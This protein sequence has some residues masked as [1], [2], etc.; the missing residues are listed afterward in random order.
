MIS[1]PKIRSKGNSK[2]SNCISK[3][4]HQ[5]V[6]N[7]GH[8]N[9][10]SNSSFRKNTTRAQTAHNW[11]TT[12]FVQDFFQCSCICLAS[13]LVW[14]ADIFWRPQFPFLLYTKRARELFWSQRWRNISGGYL[15]AER[16]ERKF[17]VHGVWNIG[18]I[19]IWYF[20][21]ENRYINIWIL[22]WRKQIYIWE[23]LLCSPSFWNNKHSKQKHSQ[24]KRLIVKY[25]ILILGQ[26]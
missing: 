22:R 16:I 12:R 21:G 15:G 19:F 8:K 14:I 17:T 2:L 9:Y 1:T 11:K 7:L 3:K 26:F 23:E 24:I 18:I 25:L 20:V 5:S 6:W 13:I 4:G 10:G